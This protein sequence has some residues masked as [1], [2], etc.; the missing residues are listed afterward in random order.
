MNEKER[1]E[2]LLKMMEEEQN[3]SWSGV[4][5]SQ[6][7]DK[8]SRSTV[9]SSPKGDG[10]VSTVIPYKNKP[11]LFAYYL[12][13]FCILCPPILCLP[14]IILGIFGLK[15]VH[16]NPAVKGTGHAIV[17]IISGAVFLL[18]SIFFLFSG[19]L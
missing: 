18:L 19:L 11:A 12:G 14:A 10:V 8:G 1:Q 7:T 15:N 4:S 5:G 16:A 9:T 3:Q 17:G 13:V 2:K 6:S